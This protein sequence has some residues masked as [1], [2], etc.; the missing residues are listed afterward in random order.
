MK[1]TASTVLVTAS[2]GL[3]SQASAVLLASWDTFGNASTR[4]ANGFIGTANPNVAADFTAAGVT[5]TLTDDPTTANSDIIRDIRTNNGSDDGTFGSSFMGAST[6]VGQLRLGNTNTASAS[7]DIFLDVING[8]GQTIG[9]D[10]VF[11]DFQA[12]TANGNTHNA[13][14]I[15]FETGGSSVFLGSGTVANDGNYTDVDVDASAATLAD[16]AT[17]RFV[18]TFSGATSPSSSSFIDNVGFSGE[19]IPEPSSAI[20]LG[21]GGLALIMRRRK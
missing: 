15:S 9:F 21:L 14:S 5:A 2:L 4:A 20:L 11:F 7:G 17:G 6:T 10:D 19:A 18:I 13:Y 12:Q 1:K 16:G 3:A 8:S